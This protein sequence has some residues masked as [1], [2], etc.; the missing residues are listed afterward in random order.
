MYIQPEN[1][2]RVPSE[3]DTKKKERNNKNNTK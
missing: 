1:Y 2:N 3:P